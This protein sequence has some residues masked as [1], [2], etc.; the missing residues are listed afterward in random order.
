MRVFSKEADQYFG[1]HTDP[2]MSGAKAVI[3]THMAIQGTLNKAKGIEN[4]SEEGFLSMVKSAFGGFEHGYQ[5]SVTG[6]LYHGKVPKDL[7]PN[8]LDSSARIG[9]QVGQMVGIFLR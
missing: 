4:N 6:L 2:D 7:D 9:S 5:N 8:N 1:I 3:D